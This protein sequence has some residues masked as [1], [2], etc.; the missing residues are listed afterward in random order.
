MRKLRI[1]VNRGRGWTLRAEGK[2]SAHTSG[3]QIARGLQ[4]YAIQHPH[5][6]LLDGVEVARAVA[7]V[8]ARPRIA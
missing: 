1:E 6:A 5:R 7:G 8:T 2:V 4:A 3:Q